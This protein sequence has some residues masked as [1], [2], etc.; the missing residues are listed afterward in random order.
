MTILRNP[1]PMESIVT[2]TGLTAA[3]VASI[4]LS[5]EL[6]GRVVSEHGRYTRKSS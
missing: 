5:M 2:R 6:G 3:K 4:L 1:T